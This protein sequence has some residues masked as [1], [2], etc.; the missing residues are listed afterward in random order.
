ME[1]WFTQAIPLKNG[2]SSCESR[3]SFI[4]LQKHH[5]GM[6]EPNILPNLNKYNLKLI[7]VRSQDKAAEYVCKLYEDTTFVCAEGNRKWYETYDGASKQITNRIL[8]PWMW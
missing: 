6:Q 4:G 3:P 8:E 2:R 5:K 1:W 7:R